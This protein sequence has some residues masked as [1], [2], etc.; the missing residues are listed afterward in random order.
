MRKFVK[1]TA[2]ETERLLAATSQYTQHKSPP[3]SIDTPHTYWVD[4]AAKVGT[5][6]HIQCRQKFLNSLRPHQ[7]H[8]R[9]TPQHD[10]DLL[11]AVRL[12]GTRQWSRIAQLAFE[13]RRTADQCRQRYERLRDRDGRLLSYGLVWQNWEVV[14]FDEAIRRNVHVG[15]QGWDRM[16]AHVGSRSPLQCRQ[17]YYQLEQHR[18]PS[19]ED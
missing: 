14:R 19:R 3:H 16:A 2:A 4:V 8:G 9:W 15:S 1:W 13:G 12:H 7:M 17:R 10:L 6:S 5:R 18:R 11:D